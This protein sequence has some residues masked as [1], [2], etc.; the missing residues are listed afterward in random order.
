M[1]EVLVAADSDSGTAPRASSNIRH[2]CRME[3]E[4]GGQIVMD[5]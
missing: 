2:L 5:E 4:G 1:T 3:I